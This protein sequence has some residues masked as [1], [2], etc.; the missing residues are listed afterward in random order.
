[1]FRTVFILMFT[2]LG[3]FAQEALK[4]LNYNLNYIHRDLAAEKQLAAPLAYK[5]LSASLNIPFLEDFY[6][7]PTKSYP[8][9]NKWS[10]E[11]AYVNSGYGIAPP[12]IGV[13]TF[14]GLNKFGFP[15]YP[16]LTN[17]ALSR[18]S[19]TLTSRAIN[20]LTTATSQTLQISDS[21]ALSFYY[22]AR[23]FGD[24]PE[25][26]D[27]LVLDFFSPGKNQWINSVWFSKGNANGNIYDTVFKRG[28]VKIDSADYL[29]DGFKFRFRNK[30][31][32]TG[33]YDHWH[34]DYIYLD[35]DRS[36]KNDT[37]YNDIAFAY[38]PT[39]FLRDYSAMP[40][41]QYSPSERV[42]NNKV[43][44]KNN[45][46][47]GVNMTY[48]YKIDTS[49][50]P[51]LHSY[52]GGAFVLN[53]F[54]PGGYDNNV[55]HASP[56]FTYTFPP[57]PDS[58]D[59]RIKHYIFRSGSSADFIAEN[60]TVIQY[61]KFR[62]YYAL[63]DGSAEAGYYINAAGGKIAIKINVNVADSFLGARIYF[64]PVSSVQ[65]QTNSLGF[66]IAVWSPG[67]NGPGILQFRDTIFRPMYYNLAPDRSFAEFKLVRPKLLQPGT[68]YIGIQ[69]FADYITFGFDMNTDHSATTYYD[70]G[71]GW[72][73]STEKGSVMIRPV[74]GKT[75]P[76]PP[77]GIAEGVAN[78]DNPFI[79]FPNPASEQLIIRTQQPENAAY[80]LV[81]VIGEQISAGAVAHPDQMINTSSLS[82]GMYLLVLT[83]DGRKVQQ[84]KIIIQH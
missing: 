55:N 59:Y 35:K 62:N 32:G 43:K 73:Q 31:A 53:P 47:L 23:G 18:E 39:P 8:D 64:D 6:Y 49:T 60:D 9:Q 51:I 17:N 28:F 78:E 25:L 16:T 48:E 69:Q 83:V 45:G 70:S 79:V 19:D 81:N 30:S 40:W 29:K 75:L 77:V 3:G 27:S 37:A 84:Q 68:Y 7:S 67:A 74:F 5:T 38:V 15:Y 46:I 2:T 61:Q 1:M 41:E 13:A 21:L 72:T 54:K 22:Q 36:R 58:I 50:S 20:L 82:N 11:M 33:N 80:S 63:D 26:T 76:P 56:P 24:S 10:D 71:S 34:L 65:S 42:N 66:R 14:D 52:T 44:I 4:P 12:S 57:M